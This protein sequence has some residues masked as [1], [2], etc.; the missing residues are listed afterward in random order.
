MLLRNLRA[1]TDKRNGSR[2]LPRW[3]FSAAL[4]GAAC[5]A[6]EPRFV[7]A[8]EVAYFTSSD[9][10]GGAIWRSELG[11]GK[12]ERLLAHES[13]DGRPMMVTVFGDSLYWTTYYPGQ[14]WTSRLD[15]SDARMLVDQG[16]ETTT[17]GIHIE[18]GSLYWANEVLGAVFRADLD[19]TNVET[20]IS[21]F[22]GY[23]E[24]IWDFEIHEGRVYWASW[25]SPAIKSTR[26]DGSDFR[27]IALVGMERAFGIEI[28]GGRL[29]VADNHR[30]Q[31][32][33][34]SAPLEGGET[35][36]L[37]GGLM[38]LSAIDILDGRLY[39]ASLLLDPLRGLIHSLPLEG[40]EPR[41]DLEAED[42]QIWQIHLVSEPSQ[43]PGDCS[44]DGTIDI[45]D[46]LCILGF[47]FVGDPPTLPCGA[48]LATD[49]GNVAIADLQ[50]DGTVDVSDAIA[51]LR[52]LFLGEQAPGIAVVGEPDCEALP[53]CPQNPGCR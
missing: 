37:L 32:R 2:G 31:G 17:R 45:S 24:G 44:Q 15:G 9:G 33:V 47:L 30:A 36:E 23:S 40:G 21:G 3:S 27:T 16:P 5:A 38:D 43:V 10:D 53:G 26:L 1:E 34:V 29:I 12:A 41:V 13:P 20:V 7:A 4:L 22:E 6:Q 39:T 8:A 35:V 42:V 18:S 14:V 48:G 49:A 11:S 25:D 46:S 28:A 50:G 52:R 51:I 19:G